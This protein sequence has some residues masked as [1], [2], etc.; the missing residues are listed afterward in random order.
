M[1]KKKTDIYKDSSMPVEDRTKDLLAR[2]TLEEKLSQVTSAWIKTILDD[3]QLFAKDKAKTILKHGIGQISRPGGGTRLLPADVA[4]NINKIQHFLI[5]NTRLGI[6]AIMHEESLMGYQMRGA[7]I[8]PQSIGVASTW[9]TD[10]V[11]E[12]ANAIRSEL[13]T[14]KIHQCLAPLCDISRD[15]RW[16]RNEETYGEDPYLVASMAKAYIEAIQGDDP[17]DRLIA[18]AKHFAGY[19]STEGGLNWAPSHL[20]ERE[21]REMFLFPFEVAVKNAGVGSI[22]NAYNEHDG[23]PCGANRWLLTDVLRKE[24]GFDGIVVSDYDTIIKLHSYHHAASSPEDAACRTLSAGL[25]VELPDR[26]CINE[27]LQR[28]FERGQISMELLNETVARIL[29]VKFRLGIFD[30]PYIVMENVNN[31]F[32]TDKS[33]AI[34]R[35][36]AQKSII[37]LKN[38]NNL[39]PLVKDFKKISVIGPNA[40]SWRHLLGD[41]SYPAIVDYGKVVREKVD[42]NSLR[43]LPNP[44]VPIVTVLDGI[45]AKVSKKTE[46]LYALGCDYMDISRDGFEEAIYIAK[47]SDVAI[48]VLGGK[49]GFSPDCTTGE[50]RDR[51]DLKLYGVQ[52]ELLKAIHETGTPIVLVIVDG[53]PI[54]LQ[55]ADDNIPAIV[56]AWLPGEEG[57]NAIADVLFGDVNPGGKLP[58]SMPRHSGQLPVFYNHKPSGRRSHHWDTYVDSPATALYPFGHGLSYTSFKYSDLRIKPERIL[59]AGSIQISVKITNYGKLAGD[60]VVQLYLNDITASVTRP[61]KELKGFK[62]ITLK[63]QES[64]Y[65]TFTLSADQLAFYDANMNL[66]VEPGEFRVMVGASSSDIRLTGEFTVSGDKRVIKGRRVYLAKVEESIND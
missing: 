35:K 42:P 20:P 41:Y 56:Q 54:S 12:M 25:D 48:L 24:W 61:V 46:I 1:P 17:K 11:T 6:P 22:M 27:K 58:V 15:P 30:D 13:R 44:T 60:E 47:Q 53:R 31:S 43:N 28:M 14:L 21:F 66:T 55:W 3:N 52:E 37:L 57:G 10:I 34:A 40:D 26:I 38:V 7:S 19:S 5:N 36:V 51:S 9:D 49:S 2:M 29:R 64:R 16:G 50:E 18:T 23:I 32:N 8:F 45:K 65:I 59:P 62:R 4:R 39:L 33:R 63:P